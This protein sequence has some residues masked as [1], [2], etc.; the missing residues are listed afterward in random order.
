MDR[1]A[2]A[3]LLQRALDYAV[4]HYGE[5]ACRYGLCLVVEHM[6]ELGYFSK[7]ERDAL[8]VV[9]EELLDEWRQG[10][11]LPDEGFVYLWVGILRRRGIPPATEQIFPHWRQA[12]EDK[13]EELETGV[14][15]G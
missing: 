4:S 13:I 15:H 2:V 3:K 12:Y 14:H 11:R 7:E 6:R 1:V 8:H 10:C 9:I 5:H